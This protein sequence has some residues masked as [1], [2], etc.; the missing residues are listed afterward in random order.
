[1]VHLHRSFQAILYQSSM[2]GPLASSQGLLKVTPRDF[3]FGRWQEV[4]IGAIHSNVLLLDLP[5][6][7]KT[8]KALAKYES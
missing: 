8:I 5:G 3:E 4:E 7:G 2:R 1:M 6:N